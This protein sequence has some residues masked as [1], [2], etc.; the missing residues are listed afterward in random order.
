[1]GVEAVESAAL[2]QFLHC[3]LCD[4]AT[5]DLG[6][7]IFFDNLEPDIGEYQVPDI[8]ASLAFLVDLQRRDSKCFLPDFPGFRVVA[9]RHAAAD[10]CLV[11]LACRPGNQLFVDKDRLEDRYIV[12]LVALREN[13]V[14]QENVARIDLITEVGENSFTNWLQGKGQHWYVFCLFQHLA[15]G[16]VQ[17]GDEIPSFVQNRRTG[18]TQ[19]H[20]P[21]F[22]SDGFQ[23][24]LQ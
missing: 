19:Q 9:T 20:Q 1:M 5:A 18:R 4:H 12:V 16:V 17:A 21:H 11:S 10:V 24:S 8:I 23:S 6:G 22:F 15:A 3:P 2:D 7:D 13:I 14:V